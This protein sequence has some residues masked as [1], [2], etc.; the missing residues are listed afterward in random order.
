VGRGYHTRA[1]ADHAEI[2]ALKEAGAR[3]R[4]AS[5]YINLEPCCHHG[6]T[7]PCVDAIVQAGVT[8][9][10][11]G[12]SDPFEK[13]AG[14]GIARLREA[15]IEVG[16]GL[17]EEKARQL[18]EVFV[19]YVTTGRPF[20]VLK[21]AMSLDGRI[22]TRGGDSKWITCEESR[23]RVHQLRDE[24]DAVLV[25]RGTVEQDDPML[26][27]RLP[28]REGKHP[29]RV[30]LDGRARMPVDA[31]VLSES[32]SGVTC[33]VVGESAESRRIRKLREA[34]AEVIRL[35]DNHGRIG[36]DTILRELGQRQVTS[37]LVEGG[38]E[39][40]T[41]ALKSGSV[42]KVVAF[43]APVILGGD[44]RFD[45]VGE[46]AVETIGDAVRLHDISVERIGDDILI[47]GYLN[48]VHRTEVKNRT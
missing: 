27:T 46:L 31:R 26:T 47:E 37:V 13:V 4:G 36:F 18:N 15:G 42:D 45:A 6:R 9:V 22:A 38:K 24:V 34:G 33:V 17:L 39:V 11:V 2:V 14:K 48:D 28:D 1:G 21:I 5:L 20:V 44:G 19:K 12:M 25:G 8:R 35:P 3:A 30:V 16:V 7:P 23:H 29:L 40:F 43:V 10:V 41:E 32:S